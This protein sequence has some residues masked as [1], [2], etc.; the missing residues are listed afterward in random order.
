MT[1]LPDSPERPA[2]DLGE[3]GEETYRRL[4]SGL[5]LGR[6]FKL[7][8]VRCNSWPVLFEVQR[9][10][11]KSLRDQGSTL[12]VIAPASVREQARIVERIESLEAQEGKSGRDGA[13]RAVVIWPQLSSEE[14]EAAWR[15][16]CRLLN[17]RREWFRHHWPHALVV[18]GSDR[19]QDLMRDEASDL[20]SI[21]SGVYVLPE[22]AASS[23]DPTRDRRETAD[24]E[25]PAATQDT[26]P[27]ATLAEAEVLLGR[28][29]PQSRALGLSRLI[30]AAGRFVNQGRSREGRLVAQHAASFVQSAG[31]RRIESDAAG[32]VARGY[33]GEGR[34]DEAEAWLRKAWDR[35]ADLDES[36]VRTRVVNALST[37]LTE[38]GKAEEAVAIRAQMGR[39]KTPR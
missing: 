26:D 18:F 13:R 3:D 11:S 6:V 24:L 37:F 21:R 9:R 27:G 33:I 36:D 20:W 5:R 25:A 1:D 35:V 7:H 10:L 39:N 22:T 29:D 31:D 17:E 19:A 15:N 2:L 12:H 32:W 30:V 8:V 23:P 16:I 34:L 14:F 28:D 38:R 4:L